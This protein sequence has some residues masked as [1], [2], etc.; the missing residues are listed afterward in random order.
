MYNVKGTLCLISFLTCLFLFFADTSYNTILLEYKLLFSV[1]NKD[2]GVDYLYR[3]ITNNFIHANKN[4]LIENV[5]LLSVC[6]IYENRVG[7][8]RFFLVFSISCLISSFSVLFISHDINSSVGASG[9]IFGLLAAQ[10][11]DGKITYTRENERLKINGLVY[12]VL[13]VLLL[14]G[15]YVVIE[16]DSNSNVNHPAHILGASSAI[17]FVLFTSKIT[18]PKTLYSKLPSMSIKK[19]PFE[20][21]V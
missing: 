2:I 11:M 12:L 7:A 3:I 4:H 8:R 21:S 9:G 17:F 14:I 19:R 13:T 1:Y 18:P 10:I 15:S 16:I 5:L 6:S 20:E